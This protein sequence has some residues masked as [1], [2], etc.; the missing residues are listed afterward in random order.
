MPSAKYL[1]VGG[2]MTAD[3][4][5]RGIRK[6][7]PSGEIALVSAE[8]HPP[9]NRPPL[10]KGLW[11]GKPLDGIW[12]KTEA[13]GVALHLGRTVRRLDLTNRKAID[14]QGREHVFEKALLATGGTPRRLPFGGDAIVYFRTLD[15]YQRLR[16]Q[17]AD[18]QR[19]GVIGGGFI[20]AEI[21]AALAGNGKQ[22]VMLFPEEGIGARLFPRGLA[23]NLNDFYRA[24]GVD[25]RPG[26][27]VT[28]LEREGRK[29]ALIAEG[30]G[31][32]PEH[33]PVD[34]VVAGLGIQPNTELA[35]DA[36]LAVDDGIVVDEQLRTSCAGVWA[37]GD[38]AAFPSAAL[39]VRMRVEHE[40]NA[41]AQGLIAGQN[42]A[43]AA[44]PYHHLP[45][46]YSDLFELGYEAVGEVDARLATI[47]DW[48]EPY[49]KGVVYYLRDAAVR[50]VLLW[51]V[52]GKV[53]AARELIAA[54]GPLRSGDLVG[55][56]RG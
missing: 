40:D 38:V 52:W 50:G 4:A 29:V 34:G 28:G 31:T 56:I 27:R 1:I 30:T 39:G 9:Y 33:T 11:K 20:G 44:L 23:L 37:A 25:V 36:D 51:N 7:D 41:L 15:D 43:G 2:G 18:G 46:F 42:L 22:V 19:F 55:R 35:R 26:A 6:L 21:A 5:V 49:R 12:R 48:E 24:K 54:K 47:E 32:H 3:A 45:F 13:E 14:D 10:S 17:A 8:A 53:D 16:V